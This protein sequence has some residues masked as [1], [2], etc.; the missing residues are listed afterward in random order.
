MIVLNKS[1]RERKISY[2]TYMWTLKNMIQK[3]V[4][5]K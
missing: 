4:F 1:D 5:T 3:T 2:I